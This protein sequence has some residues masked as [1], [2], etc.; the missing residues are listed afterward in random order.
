MNEVLSW[1]ALIG[2]AG[3]I[4]A[5][6]TFWMNRGRAEGENSATASDAKKMAL[7]AH[8]KI[9]ALDAAFGLYRENVAKEYVSRSTLHEVEIR[10][11]GAI[12]RI[13]DRLDRIIEQSSLK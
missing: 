8:I 12:D 13:T 3:S 2:A 9:G 10:I 5:I 1:G 7:E 4:I 11:T 6:V